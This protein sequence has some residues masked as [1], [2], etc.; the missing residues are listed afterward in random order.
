[1]EVILYKA[2]ASL[3]TLRGCIFDE[4]TTDVLRRGRSLRMFIYAVL[5][6]QSQS[7]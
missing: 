5:N 6:H 7:Q 3:I 2:F 1:M 4:S